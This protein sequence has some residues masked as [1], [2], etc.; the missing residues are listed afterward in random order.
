MVKLEASRDVRSWPQGHFLSSYPRMS[1]VQAVSRRS[2]QRVQLFS[3]LDETKAVAEWV[4]THD[5]GT[6]FRVL[7]QLLLFCAGF[8]G[9]GESEFHVVN[10]KVQMH[11][12]PVPLV[13]AFLLRVLSPRLSQAGKFRMCQREALLRQG[14]AWRVLKSR[15]HLYRT[16]RRQRGSEHQRL[17]ILKSCLPPYVSTHTYAAIFSTSFSILSFNSASAIFKS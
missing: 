1:A 15:M 7:E 16:A 17:Q 5:H 13:V 11:R 2:R 6:V 12:R 9:F 4:A 8:Q 10:M 3:P 14:L